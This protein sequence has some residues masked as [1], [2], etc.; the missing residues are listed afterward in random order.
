MGSDSAGSVFIELRD[1]ATE[2]THD[3]PLDIPK[4]TL[5]SEPLK[6]H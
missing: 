3:S 5:F 4:A 1:E 2:Y 6:L